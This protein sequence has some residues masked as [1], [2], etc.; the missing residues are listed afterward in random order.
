MVVEKRQTEKMGKE[1]T[2]EKGCAICYGTYT[3]TTTSGTIYTPNVTYHTWAFMESGQKLS[4]KRVPLADP[5]ATLVDV[6][7]S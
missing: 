3:T 1:R 4:N 2:K 7:H 5:L 6:P